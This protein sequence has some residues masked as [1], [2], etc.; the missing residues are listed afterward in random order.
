MLAPFLARLSRDPR[1][2]PAAGSRSFWELRPFHRPL[3]FSNEKKENPLS[4]PPPKPPQT[5][6]A[7]LHLLS[8]L[9]PPP[10][11]ARIHGNLLGNQDSVGRCGGGAVNP[12]CSQ[13]PRLR[14]RSSGSEL[15]TRQ[16][17]TAQGRAG[18]AAD[19]GPGPRRQ[20]P[21]GGRP[22]LPVG[23]VGPAGDRVGRAVWPQGRPCGGTD[24]L[25]RSPCNTAAVERAH[26]QRSGVRATC[27]PCTDSAGREP[28][29]EGQA[30][31]GPSRGY[32]WASPK[33]RRRLFRG[34]RPLL[35]ELRP[36]QVTREQSSAPGPGCL[37]P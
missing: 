7:P 32:S 1:G 21:R 37:R 14:C 33:P 18:G 31:L 30:A 22:G 24:G 2:L 23:L 16:E 6:V 9:T 28:A 5:R 20:L 17:Q 12:N 3:P 8:A 29:G 13:G 26:K 10:P 11:L 36:L 27:C 15:W 19:C 34:P 25:A 4:S 35:P